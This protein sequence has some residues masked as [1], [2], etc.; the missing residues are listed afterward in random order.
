MTPIGPIMMSNLLKREV[1]NWLEM[2][3]PKLLSKL[4]S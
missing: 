1:P 3:K 4:P 2:N